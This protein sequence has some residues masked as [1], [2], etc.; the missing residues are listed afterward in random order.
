MSAS[1]EEVEVLPLREPP[2]IL[3]HE[4][5]VLCPLAVEDVVVAG[6]V[7]RRVDAPEVAERHPNHPEQE[8]VEHGEEAE[9]ERYR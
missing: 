6:L 2:A 4:K 3:D 7:T 1:A 5:R 9:L 8:Q